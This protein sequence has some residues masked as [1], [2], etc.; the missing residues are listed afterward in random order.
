MINKII[1]GI[2]SIKLNAKPVKI[3]MIILMFATAAVAQDNEEKES[4]P[5]IPAK[6]QLTFSQTDTSRTC[7][8]VVMAGDNPVKETD[9]TFYVKRLY[10]PMPIEKAIE[11]DENGVAMVDFPMDLPGDK[12]GMIYVIAKIEEHEIYG[13]F[14]AESKVKWG[15]LP[16]VGDD[17]WGHRSLSASRDRAPMYLII[18]SNS[19]IALIWSVIFYVVFQIYRIKKAGKLTNK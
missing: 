6:I 3:L 15:V 17:D 4:E 10:Y 13:T 11:T 2:L 14:E 9:V 16:V 8:A 5:I 19:V 1:V 7:K 12:N 18:F